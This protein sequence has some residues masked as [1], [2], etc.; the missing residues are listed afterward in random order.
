MEQ[1]ECEEL[2]STYESGFSQI[3][4]ILDDDALDSEDKLDAIAELVFDDVDADSIGS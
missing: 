1:R 4:D 3:A 2:I